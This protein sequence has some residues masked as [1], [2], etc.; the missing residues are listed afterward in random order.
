MPEQLSLDNVLD[1][2]SS[3]I[4]KDK[5]EPATPA[6]APKEAPESPKL[7]EKPLAETA[8]PVE[9]SQSNRK[10]WEDR[11]QAAQGRV[12]DPETGQFATAEKVAE[13]AP[14]PTTGSPT[15]PAKPVVSAPQQDFTDKEKAFQRAMMEERGKRQELE[16]R[17]AAIETAKAAPAAAATT[18][19]PKTFWDDPEGALAKH[20]QEVRRESTNARLQTAEFIARQKHT[21]FD[22]KIEVFAK[23]L[24]Q[25]PG[26][27][28][29]WLSAPDPAEFAFTTGKNHMELEQA[30]SID[31]LHAK[32]EKETEARVRLKLETELKDK[33]EALAKERAALPPSLSEARSTG[34]NKPVWSG[35]STLDDILA[36]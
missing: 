8:P 27:E 7:G 25:T 24:Q 34:S 15:E 26:L 4:P 18:E 35:P 5:P 30:G 32:I 17:L 31:E 16:R 11:E 19:A 10:K 33:S 20:Q 12:R 6:P 29:Q 23:V 9:R 14:A 3:P 22:E 1:N 2:N 13:T 28:K 21:D 36:G